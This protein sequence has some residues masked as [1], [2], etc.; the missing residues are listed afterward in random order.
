MKSINRSHFLTKMALSASGA[1]VMLKLGYSNTGN[2]FAYK[3]ADEFV[4]I[5]IS[6]GR[7]RGVRN[8]GINIFK[9]IPYAGN[10]SGNRRFRRPASLEPWTGVC[11][12]LQLGVPTLQSGGRGGPAPVEDCLFLLLK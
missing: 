1:P 12:T 5:K 3:K 2:Y 11:D 9:G 7:I 6:H 4:D 8:E 10:I